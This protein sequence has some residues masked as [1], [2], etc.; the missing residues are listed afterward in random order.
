MVFS[1]ASDYQRGLL[2]RLGGGRAAP[3]HAEFVENEGG[4]WRGEYDYVFRRDAAERPSSKG[5]APTTD[6]VRSWR[7]R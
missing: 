7:A 5:E 3:V 6:C 1:D 4:R 2:D